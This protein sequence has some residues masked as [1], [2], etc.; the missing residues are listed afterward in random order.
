MADDEQHRKLHKKAVN[1]IV[2]G[3]PLAF[4]WIHLEDGGYQHLFSR[5]CAPLPPY[6]L[7][8]QQGDAEHHDVSPVWHESLLLGK[9]PPA[10]RTSASA[11]P[12]T[13]LQPA[14]ASS[15]SS[16]DEAPGNWMPSTLDWTTLDLQ[17][18]TPINI[19]NELGPKVWHCYPE[20]TT[21]T[22]QDPNNPYLCTIVMEEIVIAKGGGS[23]KKRANQN[24]ARVALNVLMPLI[25]L[26]GPTGKGPAGHFLGQEAATVAK[27]RALEDFTLALPF[28]DDRILKCTVGKTP[29]MVLQEHCHKH[30]GVVP[31]YTDVTDANAPRASGGR[32]GPQHF[33][34]SCKTGPLFKTASDITVKK[35]KQRVAL[36]VLR[37]LYPHVKIWGD[38]VESMNSVQR[39]HRALAQNSGNNHQ[40]RLTGPSQGRG[41]GALDDLP[42]LLAPSRTR[43][44]EV[45]VLLWE[46]IALCC[47][48]PNQAEAMGLEEGLTDE[49]VPA[50]R[51]AGECGRGAE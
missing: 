33:T 13:A 14:P 7:T 32:S 35:A 2:D 19:L 49:P 51:L 40:R 26:A 38:V 23:S 24:A 27:M 34:Y 17:E 25:K 15:A 6:R 12:S 30:V 16:R 18:K 48:N 44:G 22:E 20:I 3:L 21:T 43:L 47:G 42:A 10:R 5:V 1:S 45:N 28:D 11:A 4:G 29:I 39:E 50:A 36:V 41:P 8:E 46:Q 31:T 37:L 9:P